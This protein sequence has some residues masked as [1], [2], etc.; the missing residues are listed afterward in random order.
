M[1]VAGSH[2]TA[3]PAAAAAGTRPIERPSQAVG[4]GIH[5]SVDR[6]QD[7]DAAA[8]VRQGDR[9]AVDEGTR[10]T[11]VARA[12]RGGQGVA[13]AETR[14]SGPA[15]AGRQV[16][17]CLD[18]AVRVRCSGPPGHDAAEAIVRPA[19]RNPAIARRDALGA[20]GRAPPVDRGARG[21]A[22]E[23]RR[24]DR[25]DREPSAAA[26]GRQA[27]RSREPGAAGGVRQ[28][29]R[30]DRGAAGVGTR[31]IVRGR[32]R[33]VAA[34]THRTGGRR[35]AGGHAA[36]RPR[37]EDSGPDR[38]HP[39]G[40]P[41]LATGS[42]PV[43]AAHRFA[44]VLGDVW[45][46]PGYPLRAMRA[47]HGDHRAAGRRRDQQVAARRAGHRGGTRRRGRPGTPAP[48]A[49]PAGRTGRRGIAVHPGHRGGHEG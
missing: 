6:R 13:A 8:G 43:A 14:R 47:E 21:G 36:A 1:P 5:P 48:P 41:D 30:S 3:H 37:D 39:A 32:D 19:H 2:R 9:A 35:R 24:V 46:A 27:D 15:A 7:R 22:V 29:D 23:V 31:P 44:P 40:A 33:G 42:R 10:R 4:A 11:G 28:A 49:R 38:A 18:A 20:A 16:G 17:A 34:G 45:V 12:G 25:C 26:E